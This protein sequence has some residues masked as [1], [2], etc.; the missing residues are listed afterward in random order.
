MMPT[1]FHKSVLPLVAMGTLLA[2]VSST[3]A[4]DGK[5]VQIKELSDRLRIEINGK[6]FTEYFFKDVPR[7]YCHPLLGPNGIQMTRDWPM[8]ESPAEDRDHPHHR[9]FWFTH[10]NVNGMDFWAEGKESC[11][12]VHDG[13]VKITSGEKEGSVQ[14]RQRWIGKDGSEVCKDERTLR[15]YNRPDNERLFDYEITVTAGKSDVTFGDTKEGSMALRLAETMR[16]KHNKE[17]TGKPTGH[18][19]NSEGVRDADT[20]GK[21]AAWCDYYGPVGDKIVG[22]AIFDHPQ[23]PRHPTWWHVRDYGLFAANPFGKHDFEKLQ[24]KTAGNL[25]IPAGQSV[26]FR[27]RFYL[28]EGDEKQGKVADRYA[29]YTKA[30]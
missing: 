30:K 25:V 4:A 13:F 22:A 5:G 20:W 23:N 10:G 28:H 27:Y 1:M 17:N 9:S 3:P 6:L 19:V 29:E 2:T 15:V 11:K 26:T 8:K 24:D 16:L 12:V 7:P 18:I 14:S 21:R